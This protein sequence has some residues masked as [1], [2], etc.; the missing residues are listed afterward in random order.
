MIEHGPS[1]GHK[2][3]EGD[4]VSIR[5]VG[6]L[7][8]GGTQFDSNYAAPTPTNVT[9][10]AAS[11]IAGWNEGLLGVRTGD[12]IQ[13]DIPADLA[14]GSAGSQQPPVPPT[15]RSATSSRSK[16]SRRPQHT[17]PDG[18][19]DEVTKTVVTEGPGDGASPSR[20]TPS[21]CTSP[22]SSAPSAPRS[23]ATS[24]PGRRGRSCS[25]R[26]RSCPASTSSSRACRRATSCRS[27][28]RPRTPSVTPGRATGSSHP[29]PISPSCSRSRTSPEPLL[30]CPTRRPPSSSP[31]STPRVRPG[32]R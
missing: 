11:N 10:G 8:D 15:R 20:S 12:Q 27:T 25:A 4:V 32:R 29:T 31:P 22:P 16:T 13:L 1:Y 17:L 24:E 7:Q 18:R 3:D 5:Y 2:A 23:A 21:A 28:F 19:V 6:V 26:T 9:V 14:Y 30:T